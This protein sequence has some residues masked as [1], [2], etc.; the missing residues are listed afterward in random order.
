MRVEMGLDSAVCRIR[1]VKSRNV[2]SIRV[3]NGH[4]RNSPQ[5]T[6]IISGI[7]PTSQLPPY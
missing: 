2:I 1:D 3:R 7:Y 6:A 5:H 4:A